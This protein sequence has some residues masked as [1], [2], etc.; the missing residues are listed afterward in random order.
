MVISVTNLKNL[1]K[2]RK[3]DDGDPEISEKYVFQI[4]SFLLR[5]N[6]S[7]IFLF[8][9]LILLLQYFSFRETWDEKFFLRN[10]NKIRKFNR[11][12]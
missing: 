3:F 1:K 11:I 6:I 4:F 5:N 9:S 2:N 12:F 10:A 7:P 8:I